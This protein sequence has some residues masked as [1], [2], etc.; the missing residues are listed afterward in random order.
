MVHIKTRKI[1]V[2]G[3]QNILG[4]YLFSFNCN[5]V[6]LLTVNNFGMRFQQTC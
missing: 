6:I 5:E 1:V 2:A 3:G 4:S